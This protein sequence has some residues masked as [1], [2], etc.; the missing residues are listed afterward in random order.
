[1]YIQ[2]KVTYMQPKNKYIDLAF[3]YI[4]ITNYDTSNSCFLTSF[5]S[6]T[7]LLLLQ[8][9]SV[10]LCNLTTLKIPKI[11]DSSSYQFTI[12]V[13]GLFSTLCTKT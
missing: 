13:D 6:V 5:L 10:E 12:E 1:M 8:A 4:I 7:T 11:N 9:G 2:F 3:N